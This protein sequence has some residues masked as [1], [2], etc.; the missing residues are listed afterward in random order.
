ME[1]D[2]PQNVL[3]NPRFQ[4]GL[5]RAYFDAYTQRRLIYEA[6]LERQA[7][8]ILENAESTMSY[9]AIIDARNTNKVKSKG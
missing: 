6:S 2:A 1:K 5:I 3:A 7:R 8:N 9:I 4:S